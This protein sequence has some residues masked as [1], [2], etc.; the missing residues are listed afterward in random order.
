[1]EGEENIVVVPNMVEVEIGSGEWRV[2]FG[3][4]IAADTSHSGNHLYQPGHNN[5][6]EIMQSEIQEE[7]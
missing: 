6:P 3:H 5:L 2:R 4:K 7:E 1:M